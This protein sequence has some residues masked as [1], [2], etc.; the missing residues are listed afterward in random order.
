MLLCFVVF[1]FGKFSTL[2]PRI[3]FL[4]LKGS[5]D[6][7]RITAHEDHAYEDPFFDPF[8][9]EKLKRSCFRHFISFFIDKTI[10]TSSCVLT[11]F[12]HIYV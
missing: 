1:V 3:R 8:T 7:L 4:S 5:W 2:F 9:R 11:I 10:L 12:Q 6:L